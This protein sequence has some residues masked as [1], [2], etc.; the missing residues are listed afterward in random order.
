[1]NVEFLSMVKQL[2]FF[3]L[4]VLIGS[5][6]LEPSNS[7]ART[8]LIVL[9]EPFQGTV[10]LTSNG[11]ARTLSIGENSEIIGQ[12]CSTHGLKIDSSNQLEQTIRC[13]KIE[14]SLYQVVVEQGDSR[15]VV[16]TQD[17]GIKEDRGSYEPVGKFATVVVA[18]KVVS[19]M[20]TE[21]VYDVHVEQLIIAGTVV[22]DSVESFVTFCQSGGVA[23]NISGN[24]E[25]RLYSE[26][27]RWSY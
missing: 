27:D 5:C 19:K 25:I 21:F 20:R 18:G 23:V 6:A 12:W 16:Y 7:V 2:F 9:G 17:C 4:I 22:Q 10:L 1:M 11:F 24:S 13:H 15:L 26:G 8:E 3:S 14:D